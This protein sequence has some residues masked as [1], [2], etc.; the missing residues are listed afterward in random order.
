MLHYDFVSPRP[1]ANDAY[2]DM[3]LLTSTGDPR[4]SYTKLRNWIQ[5]AVA[6]GK[7]ARSGPCTV[8]G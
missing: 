1:G 7:V 6:D 3:G 2:F 5:D 8:C 4:A